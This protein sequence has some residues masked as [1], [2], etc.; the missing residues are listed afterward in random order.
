MKS[1]IIAPSIIQSIDPATL[2]IIGEV[3]IT[4]PDQ[5]EEMVLQARNAYPAWRD[6]G[7]SKRTAIL[8][9]SQQLLLQ[10]SE[11]FAELITREMGKPVTE[12]LSLELNASIDIIGYYAKQA[13]KFLDDKRVPLHHLLFRRRVSR[14]HFEPLGVL[15]I[16]APWNWPLL[17]PLGGIIPA[18]LSGNGVLF[19]HSELTP[20]LAEKMRELL[21]D[22]GVP[23]AIFQIIQGNAQ[24]GKALVDAPVE[25]IFFTGSTDVGREVLK[26]ASPTLKKCVLEMGGSDP[27]IVCDDAY[28]HITSS[29]LVWGGFSNCGQNCNSIE[30]I[31]V[32]EKIA[33]SLIEGIVEKTKQLRIGN[34]LDKDT[35]IGPLASEAQLIKT[36]ALVEMAQEMGA[37]VLLGGKREPGLPGYFYPPTV[38]LWEKSVPQPVDIELFGPMILITSVSSDDEAVHLANRSAFGLG[39]SVW[40]ENSGRGNRIARRIQSGTVMINDSIVSFGM[41][42]AGWTGI[43]NSGIGWVHG[44]KGLDEMV[45]MKYINRDPQSR[46]QNLWWF[47]YTWKMYISIKVGLDFMFS[48]SIFRRLKTIPTLLRAFTSFLIFN[49]SRKD[50]Y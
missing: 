18:L 15:G 29:G 5:V 6:M 19:K 13:H 38:I 50:K 40:T 16:I 34:G 42:E 3:T 37:K 1:Q 10:R 17:I 46:T 9:R 22:A 45:N 23:E 47:P 30:R 43:K 39:A 26:Q 28:P 27:A 32:H 11:S 20:L 14:T 44:E 36:E 48:K 35:D 31:Y 24:Q 2:E 4:P 49:R 21:L 33:G 7:L 41:T 12:S 25:K 8:K